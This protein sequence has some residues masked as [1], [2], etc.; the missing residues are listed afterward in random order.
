MSFL[1]IS[2]AENVRFDRAAVARTLESIPDVTNARDVQSA[3]RY[4]DLRWTY[5]SAEGMIDCLLMKDGRAIEIDD[6]TRR[7]CDFILN[8]ARQWPASLDLINDDYSL[9]LS[10]AGF[11]DIDELW[12]SINAAYEA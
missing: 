6:E 7:A 11:R 2:S 8:F 12:N 10:L 4:A 9:H 1:L 5:E 3:D